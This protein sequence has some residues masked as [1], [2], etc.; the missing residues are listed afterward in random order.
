TQQDVSQKPTRDL[1]S[2]SRVERRRQCS[3]AH[4][5]P[6]SPRFTFDQNDSPSSAPPVSTSGSRGGGLGAGGGVASAEC[7]GDSETTRGPPPAPPAPPASR[8]AVTAERL[9]YRRGRGKLGRHQFDPRLEIRVH[10]D[11]P[12][13][14]DLGGRHAWP[15]RTPTE[16]GAA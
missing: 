11:D 6:V 14:R 1:G 15:A 10:L 7:V 13:L 3:A 16:P 5:P 4:V 9:R 2:R 12:D 8:R